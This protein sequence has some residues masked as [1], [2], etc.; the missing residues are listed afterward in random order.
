MIDAER[1]AMS[2]LLACRFQR[3]SKA[4]SFLE[5]LRWELNRNPNYKNTF[6]Q[7]HHLWRL[8]WKYRRQIQ[9]IEITSLAF[10]H[11]Q[12]GKLPD[13]YR[14]GDV[15]PEGREEFLAEQTEREEFQK[16][17]KQRVANSRRLF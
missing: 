9:N 4:S 6:A 7:A 12:T 1:K 10:Y 8:V 16:G 2:L 14:D 17:A 3:G 5:D 11:H 13:L 15:R